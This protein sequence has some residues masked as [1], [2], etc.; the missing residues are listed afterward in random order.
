MAGRRDAASWLEGPGPLRGASQAFPGERLGRPQTGPG[1]VGPIGRRLIGVVVDW[2][3][4]LLIGNALLRST[5][6]GSFAP[7]AVFLT[8]HVLLVG[9]AGATIGHRL[10][11]LRV[12]TLTGQAPG[13]V[14]ALARSVLLCLAVPALIWDRDQR[15]LHDKVAGT[16][17]ARR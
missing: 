9:T 17:V 6:W 3:I 5:G 13:P 1:S 14:R 12:E 10:A 8:E 7:L 16:L 15:G 4:A 2:L 11:G